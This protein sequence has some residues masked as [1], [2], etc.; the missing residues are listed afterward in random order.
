MSIKIVHNHLHKNNRLYF[1]R[2]FL[3]S[4]RITMLNHCFLKIDLKG[5]NAFFKR[6][7]THLPTLLKEYLLGEATNKNPFKK[8]EVT[9]LNSSR[10]LRVKTFVFY[11]YK[12]IPYYAG[13]NTENSIIFLKNL[14]PRIL[15]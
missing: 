12:I 7:N 10:V 2:P 1:F 6:Y 3:N 5:Y 8:F 15:I 11:D 14:R 4:K 13:Y 9:L